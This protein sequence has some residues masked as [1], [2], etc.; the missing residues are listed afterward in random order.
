MVSSHIHGICCSHVDT[1]SGYHV[2][3][4]SILRHAR[5]EECL[6]SRF[7]VRRLW[8]KHVGLSLPWFREGGA[9]RDRGGW[10][11]RWVQYHSAFLAYCASAALIDYRDGHCTELHVDLERL[12]PSVPR[13]RQLHDK[14]SRVGT[15]LRT[16]SCRS[17]RQAMGVDFSFGP[18]NY[19]PYCHNLPIPA[20]IYC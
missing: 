20:K 5:T 16:N 14:D 4:D 7:H 3:V 1:F 10:N 9:E 15:L 19:C 2:P 12:P 8:A 6:W 11:H 17:I 18:C 13:N